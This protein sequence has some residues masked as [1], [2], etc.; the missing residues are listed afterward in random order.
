MK[1]NSGFSLIGLVIFMVVAGIALPPL[2]IIAYNSVQN[3]VATEVMLNSVNLANEK[4]EDLKTL[5]F[6]N[7]VNQTGS[8]SGAF[9]Q[10]SYSVTVYYVSPPNYDLSVNP[11]VT[12]Y[13]RVV[14][15]VT[16]NIV[17]EMQSNLV[18]L[19]SKP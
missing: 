14:V 7:L 17:S 13:K 3:S 5:S 15:V 18:T 6:T 4:M 16:N 10:Y 12:N 1:N 9:S 8:F 2:L 11:T 19:I